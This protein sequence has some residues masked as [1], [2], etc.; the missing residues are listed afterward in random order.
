MVHQSR[1]SHHI[2]ESGFFPLDNG[3]TCWA[4]FIRLLSDKRDDVQEQP[5]GMVQRRTFEEDSWELELKR[6]AG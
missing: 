4:H 5:L 1:P 2:P 3:I 6:D